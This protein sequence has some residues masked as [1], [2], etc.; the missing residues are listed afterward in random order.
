MTLTA[1]S[2]TALKQP[3]WHAALVILCGAFA[4]DAAVWA[5]VSPGVQLDLTDLAG[6]RDGRE[7]TLLRFAQGLVDGADTYVPVAELGALG[8]CDLR[9]VF[10]AVA[11]ASGRVLPID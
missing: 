3:E 10:D 9:L 7:R 2:P 4:R 8:E 11:I 1:L 5:R 6:A